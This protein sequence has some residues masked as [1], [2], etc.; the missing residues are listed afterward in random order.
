MGWWFEL[1]SGQSLLLF[2]GSHANKAEA[3]RA[4]EVAKTIWSSS[5]E[6]KT[7]SVRLGISARN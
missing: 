5:K 2:G 4:A 1:R 6:S 7:L 3:E